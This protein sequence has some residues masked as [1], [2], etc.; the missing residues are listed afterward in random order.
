MSGE[1]LAQLVGGDSDFNYEVDYSCHDSSE[2]NTR[3]C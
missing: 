2:I 3:Q 1:Q